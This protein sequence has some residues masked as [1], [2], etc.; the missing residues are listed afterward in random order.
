MLRDHTSQQEENVRAN[1][2]RPIY[3]ICWQHSGLLELLSCSGNVVFDSMAFN[4]TGTKIR[5]IADSQS[6]I[7]TMPATAQ[8]ITEVQNSTWRDGECKIY[9]LPAKPA[10]SSGY[11]RAES[12]LQLNGTII[13]SSFSGELITVN[14]VQ[15]SFDGKLSPRNR[16]DEFGSH[17]PAA[18]TVLTWEGSQ[19]VLVARK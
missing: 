18:G 16:L 1:E 10:S 12:I 4:P 6:A 2:T 13:S 7:I 3:L 5:S 14:A 9:C 11:T 15:N 8:R 19:V 17:M